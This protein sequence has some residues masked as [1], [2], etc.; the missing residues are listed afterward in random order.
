MIKSSTG[1]YNKYIQGGIVN[2]YAPKIRA[3]KS[4]KQTLREKYIAI[5]LFDR[6]QYL[7]L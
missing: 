2:T 3:H 7:I 6:L 4:I 1:R 5:K